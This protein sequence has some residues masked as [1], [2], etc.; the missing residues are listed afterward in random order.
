ML[1]L[2][3]DSNVRWPRIMLKGR[4]QETRGARAKPTQGE[5]AIME[6]DA[7]R[8]DAHSLHV[9]LS[10][11]FP[12]DRDCEELAKFLGS[13]YG[14][15]EYALIA[16]PKRGASGASGLGELEIVSVSG[17]ADAREDG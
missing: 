1:D 11:K 14:F 12:A 8:R 15:L 10:A 17:F 13:I 6:C 7:A 4:N 16:S 5:I 9:Q 2:V 3:D